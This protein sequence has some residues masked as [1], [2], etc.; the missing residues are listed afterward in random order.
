MCDELQICGTCKDY[1]RKT[2]ESGKC[3]VA[4]Q[5]VFA[6]DVKPCWRSRRGGGFGAMMM[7]VMMALG[8]GA[9]LAGIWSAAFAGR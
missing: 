7:L 4:D 8:I 2:T 1:R 3:D 9:L 5:P 6:N